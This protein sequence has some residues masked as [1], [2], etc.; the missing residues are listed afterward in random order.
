[1]RWKG[2]NEWKHAEDLEGA[3]EIVNKFEVME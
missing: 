3:Q 1:M 2:F